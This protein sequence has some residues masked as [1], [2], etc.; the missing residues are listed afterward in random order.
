MLVFYVLIGNIFDESKNTALLLKMIKSN[1]LCLFPRRW[2][3]CGRCNF[4]GLTKGLAA[5][6]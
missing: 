3:S 2:F 4:S 1:T 6:P 5:S